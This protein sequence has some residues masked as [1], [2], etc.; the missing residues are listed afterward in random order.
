[1][2]V[3]LHHYR[4]YNKNNTEQQ[5]NYKAIKISTQTEHR[6]YKYITYYKNSLSLSLSLTHTHTHTHTHYK[7]QV[8]TTTVQDTHQ[9]K[10]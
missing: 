7:T 9:M 8:K 6:K 1:V 5:N 2:A 3:V 4:Q 10:Y